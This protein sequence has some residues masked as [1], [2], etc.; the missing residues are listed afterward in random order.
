M[1]LLWGVV[2]KQ[3]ACAMGAG[4]GVGHYGLHGET[5]GKG[6]W[7][8]VGR[9][10]AQC[11]VPPLPH[12]CPSPTSCPPRGGATMTGGRDGCGW[13]EPDRAGQRGCGALGPIEPHRAQGAPKSPIGTH[14]V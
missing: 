4:G 10:L 2:G 11:H 7:G 8:G 3:S 5:R 12:S 13:A 6:P 14:R 9:V 1:W